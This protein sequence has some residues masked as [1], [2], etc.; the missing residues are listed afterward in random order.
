V[1]PPTERAAVVQRRVEDVRVLREDILPIAGPVIRPTRVRQQPVDDR[2]PVRLGLERLDLRKRRRD[3]RGIQIDPAQKG[4]VIGQTSQRQVIG[5]CLGPMGPLADPLAQHRD[6]F[7][8]ERLAFRRHELVRI[9]RGDAGEDRAFLWLAGKKAR[10]VR[11]AALEGS[12]AVVEPQPAFRLA[13][14]VTLITG[15]LQHRQDLGEIIHRARAGSR[16]LPSSPGRSWRRGNGRSR[17]ARDTRRAEPAE[18]S[19]GKRRAIR[20][21]WRERPSQYALCWERSPSRAEALT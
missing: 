6:L 13:A 1:D 7:R 21:Q 14:L 15:E 18:R 11:L 5:S 2:C 16:P 10:A 3:A 4:E 19:P 12:G 17:F 9:V 20:E 8:A